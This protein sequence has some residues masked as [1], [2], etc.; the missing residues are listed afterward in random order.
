MQALKNYFEREWNNSTF[1]TNDNAYIDLSQT[2]NMTILRTTAKVEDIIKYN[3]S[4]GLGRDHGFGNQNWVRPID[5]GRTEKTSAW[6]LTLLSKAY[7]LTRR[8]IFHYKYYYQQRIIGKR[9]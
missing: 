6:N 4:A 9:C 1:I 3:A 8:T 7:V 2:G 5:I